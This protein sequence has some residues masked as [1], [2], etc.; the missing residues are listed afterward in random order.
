MWIFGGLK[1][2]KSQHLESVFEQSILNVNLD[3]D[4]HSGPN[5]SH[6][7]AI[8]M[9]SNLETTLNVQNIQL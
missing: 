7:I 2:F 6:L 1:G 3:S 5:V 4:K 9:E 8:D